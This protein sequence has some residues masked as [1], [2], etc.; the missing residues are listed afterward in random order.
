MAKQKRK[1]ANFIELGERRAVIE[2]ANPTLDMNGDCAAWAMTLAA[3]TAQLDID[4]TQIAQDIIDI[5]N[6]KRDEYDWYNEYWFGIHGAVPNELTMELCHGYFEEPFFKVFPFGEFTLSRLAKSLKQVPIAMVGT[7][8]H[9]TF[10]GSGTIYDN[11]NST[12]RYVD[13]VV[14]PRSN[15][16]LVRGILEDLDRQYSKREE[17]E[18]DLTSEENWIR[19]EMQER[20]EK[21]PIYRAVIHPLA[22]AKCERM[23]V[24]LRDWDN[25]ITQFSLEIT[26]PNWVPLLLSNRPRIEEELVRNGIIRIMETTGRRMQPLV[27]GTVS[28]IEVLGRLNFD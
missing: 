21:D 15:A 11:W 23:A 7:R 25:L 10:V 2:A 19:V 20:I 9:I 1:P 18:R 26:D 24:S 27:L 6:V 13:D 28:T 8:N 22:K 14:V 16:L 12:R 4:Y 3:Q 17:S 5:K